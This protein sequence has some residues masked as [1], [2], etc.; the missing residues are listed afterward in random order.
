MK[1]IL[2]NKLVGPAVNILEAKTA[3]ELLKAAQGVS[4]W[5]KWT[6]LAFDTMWKA[7]NQE[8]GEITPTEDNSEASFYE[9]KAVDDKSRAAVDTLKLINEILDNPSLGAAT[10][11]TSLAVIPGTGAYDVTKQVESLKS[12][13]T[14]DNMGLMKGVLSDSDIKILTSAATSLDVGMKKEDFVNEL[15][16]IKTKIETGLDT[17]TP[18]EGGESVSQIGTYDPNKTYDKIGYE[19]KPE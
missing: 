15:E 9:S 10:G 14:L 11:V 18:T 5:D 19:V 7:I 12:Q 3:T 13:Q 16:R 6:Y 4:K 2:I 1:K 17:Y 8:G